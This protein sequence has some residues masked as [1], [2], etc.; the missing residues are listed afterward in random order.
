MLEPAKRALAR[1]YAGDGELLI[2]RAHRIA[3]MTCLL[4]STP[5]FD[6]NRTRAN[7]SGLL[8]DQWRWGV[9]IGE[10]TAALQMAG[11][12]CVS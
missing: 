5:S 1:L 10:G 11:G 9:G 2:Q 7:I 12:Q 4:A 6:A 3:Q 8:P